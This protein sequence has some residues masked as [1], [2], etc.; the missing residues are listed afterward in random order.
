MTAEFYPIVYD[1]PRLYKE[2]VARLH[3]QWGSPQEEVLVR[4]ASLGVLIAGLFL[5]GRP[6][7]VKASY[8]PGADPPHC[9]PVT[10]TVEHRVEGVIIVENTVGGL[11][12]RLV[13][14][15]SPEG[16]CTTGVTIYEPLH[17][18]Q[19]TVYEAPETVQGFFIRETY[20]QHAE[21]GGIPIG[22]E[23]RLL[24]PED[25][26]EICTD[27]KPNLGGSIMKLF[28]LNCHQARDITKKTATL[29]FAESFTIAWENCTTAWEQAIQ[30]T[31]Q[32]IV[33][34]AESHPGKAASLILSTLNTIIN[35]PLLLLHSKSEKKEESKSSKLEKLAIILFGWP[36]Y[37]GGVVYLLLNAIF[38]R[39][40]KRQKDKRQ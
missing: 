35:L 25:R 21:S 13:P 5:L 33:N 3:G 8:L 4:K 36:I 32:N 29:T 26:I 28:N 23:P 31:K 18:N 22:T 40:D 15:G 27:T 20:Q 39:Q 9:N 12:A 11:I 2:K 30:V 1:P 7:E 17:G 10:N 16:L 6:N 34:W 38:D 24:N 37:T 14:V 19:V